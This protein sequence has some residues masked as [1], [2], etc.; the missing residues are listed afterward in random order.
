MS[1]ASCYVVIN[2]HSS[3]VTSHLRQI[4]RFFVWFS[5]NNQLRVNAM[6]RFLHRP[7][8]LPCRTW[9]G[10]LGSGE[11]VEKDEER[12]RYWCLRE[13]TVPFMCVDLTYLIGNV[14][15]DRLMTCQIT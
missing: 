4:G 3:N 14:T 10:A 15:E 5:P 2:V 11:T 6:Q 9:V 7:R 13:G 12:I 8:Y 1:T